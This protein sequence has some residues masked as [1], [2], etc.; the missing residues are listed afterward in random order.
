MRWSVV[1]WCAMA[2]L[3]TL[4][5]PA[6]AHVSSSPPVEAMPPPLETLSAAAPSLDGVGI[7]AAVLASALILIGRGRRAVVVACVLLL[8]L[9]AFE[10]GVHSVHHL[11]DQPDGQCV[12]ASASAHIGGVAVTSVA[13]DRPAETVTALAVASMASP[14]ARPAAPDLGRA[15]VA[16]ARPRRH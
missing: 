5:T 4:S 15:P 11:A 12:V 13:F 8:L 3:L 10:S 1:G 9:V 16:P 6:L 7:L 2:V 14:I